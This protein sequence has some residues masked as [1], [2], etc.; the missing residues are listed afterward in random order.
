MENTSPALLEF[1]TI[2]LDDFVQTPKTK[3]VV[4]F[5]KPPPKTTLVSTSLIAIDNILDYIP[6]VST[7]NNLVDL[8][9]KHVVF[10][11]TDPESSEFKQYLK[12]LKDKE[13]TTCLV[14]S[15]PVIGNIL[16]IGVS[17]HSLFFSSKPPASALTKKELLQSQLA[18]R[19]HP[20]MP[21]VVTAGNEEKLPFTI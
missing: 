18:L 10:K 15:I 16:K 19:N 5:Q 12:H 3:A 20:I 1:Q 7:A 21:K 14:Y 13:T 4:P 9:L 2:P 6:L 17:T 11:D 8:G